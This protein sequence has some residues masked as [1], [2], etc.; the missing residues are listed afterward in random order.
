MQTI[1]LEVT[2]EIAEAYQ[3]ASLE[4]RQQIQEI[5]SLLLKKEKENDIDFLRKI[6]DEISDR[7]TARGLTPEILE[8]II[9]EP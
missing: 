1:T 4:E 3:F 2:S 6:M 9:N 5:V 8:S 7:A